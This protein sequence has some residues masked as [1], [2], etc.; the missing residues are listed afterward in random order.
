MEPILRLETGMHT[1]PLG[2]IDVDAQNRFLVT[3]SSDKTVRLWELPTGKPIRILR[4]P[5]GEGVVGR[6]YSVAITPDG[7]T[8]ACGGRTGFAWE[9]SQSIYLFD[10]ESGKLVH[11]IKGLPDVG[12]FH[13]VYSKDGRFLAVTLGGKEGIRIYH[14]RDYS[15]AGEDKDYG[16]SRPSADFDVNGRLATASMMVLSASTGV[17]SG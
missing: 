9:K 6:I 5:I 11:R 7:S 1:A 16:D 12:V 8:I 13:V 10:R 2:R 4:L 14:T 17:I 3:G 15:I